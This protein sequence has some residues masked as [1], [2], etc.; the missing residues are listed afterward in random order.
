M[1]DY[2]PAAGRL[3]AAMA[4]IS[5]RRRPIRDGAARSNERNWRIFSGSFRASGPMVRQQEYRWKD[6][7]AR[8]TCRDTSENSNARPVRLAPGSEFIAAMGPAAVETFSA[9]M[10][11]RIINPEVWPDYACL[12]YTSPSPRD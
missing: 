10:P 4:T 12:L 5:A 8:R 11:P 1:P 6:G 7:T 2:A 9:K 3:A